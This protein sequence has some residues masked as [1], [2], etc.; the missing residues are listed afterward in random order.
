MR[1]KGVKSLL[2]LTILIST[3]L[4]PSDIDILLDHLVEK[5][6]IDGP[7]AY[8]IRYQTDEE[9]K[10]QI[11]KRTHRTLPLWLQSTT[12]QGDIRIRYQDEAN[13]NLPYK[14]KRARIRARM[15][16]E[17]KVNERSFLYIGLTS[18]ENTDPRSKNQTMTDN[19]SK[20]G[21]YLDYAYA[22]MMLSRNT[23]F[24]AGKIKSPFFI[25]NDAIWDSDINQEGFT[26]TH[27]KNLTSKLKSSL[28]GGLFI[29]K[30]NKD[31]KDQKLHYY[32]A[33][34]DIANA[35]ATRKGWIAINQFDFKNIKGAQ[36]LPFRPS[37][38]T[39][40]QAN[41]TNSSG[42]LYNY[43]VTS[44]DLDAIDIFE[45]PLSILT[46]DIKSIAIFGSVFKNTAISTSKHNE[47]YLVGIR[48]GDE[49]VSDQGEFQISL[50]KRYIEKDA[51]LDSYPD[52]DF[53]GGATDVKGYKLTFRYGIGYNSNININYFY[54]KP[55]LTTNKKRE[56]VLQVDLN[57]R[58]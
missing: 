47:G 27:E 9:I 41:T 56:R 55:I 4:Y 5:G 16:I 12:L 11:S 48:V 24:I 22:E 23:A 36:P 6:V 31:A 14:R 51:T 46:M 58:F 54:S 52:S 13:G 19:F 57:L 18:G 7:T 49:K 50:S 2:T 34:V 28:K 53:Y 32:S 3:Q 37:T 30:E 21:I 43:R 44:I 39:Y 10:K 45:T 35:R 33:K 42:Y 29:L 17:S 8:E 26:I 38:T 15:A 40:I 1:K 25:S 20:K